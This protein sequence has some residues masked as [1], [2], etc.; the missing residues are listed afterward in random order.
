MSRDNRDKKWFFEQFLK[1]QVKQ[2]NYIALPAAHIETV[3]E[4]L[5][6]LFPNQS[7][8]SFKELGD[9]LS[10]PI[11]KPMPR[12]R[13]KLLLETLR[14]LDLKS[15]HQ[16]M[17][18]QRVLA[19]PSI[20]LSFTNNNS[21]V[22]AS[23]LRKTAGP[24]KLKKPLN[25]TRRLASTNSTQKTGVAI[26]RPSLVKQTPTTA[27]M[28]M[29]YAGRNNSDPCSDP[30]R[31]LSYALRE[32]IQRVAG[33]G[34]GTRDCT[35]FCATDQELER[36]RT[37]IIEAFTEARV[38]TN[39]AQ[40]FF[41]PF[42]LVIRKPEDKDQTVSFVPYQ[43]PKDG[44]SLAGVE[45]EFNLQPVPPERRDEVVRIQQALFSIKPKHGSKPTA[46]AP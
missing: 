34:L 44:Q 6:E 18:V 35:V 39:P 42:A 8:R 1:R 27:R 37:S 40:V 14:T 2:K 36:I 38:I 23:E 11:T 30:N 10:Q 9:I 19:Q 46:V 16:R 41:R 21:W 13:A 7:F 28:S 5:D 15:P 26:T 22:E 45:I 33:V 29:D 24:L 31:F 43:G 12:R 3:K 17:V 32:A 25:L 20:M 4:V